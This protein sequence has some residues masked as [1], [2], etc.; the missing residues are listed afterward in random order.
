MTHTMPC[1]YFIP[2]ERFDGAGFVHPARLPLGAAFRGHCGAPQHHGTSPSD[3]ELKQCNLGYARNCARLPEE[4]EADAVR[5]SILRERDGKISICYV[6][7]LN[8]L[9]RESGQLHYESLSQRWI[10]T[11]PK[12]RV[13]TLAECFLQSYLA[14]R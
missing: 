6:E 4:R 2:T 13:Q 10:Q 1:P 9:P 3:V 14:R 8:Y 12:P 11:H 7:E 5:F